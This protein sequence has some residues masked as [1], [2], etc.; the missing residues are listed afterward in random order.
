MWRQSTLNPESNVQFGEGGAGT[1]SDGKL[2][3]QIKDPHFL[4]RKVLSEFV[5][6][7][8]PPEI[9]YAS[10]PHIGT[11]KL[12]SMVEIMRATIESLGGEI[13]FEQRVIDI[14]IEEAAGERRVCGVML[15]GGESIATNHLVLA[16]GH[17][18]R[19]TFQCLHER[20]VFMDKTVRRAINAKK[21]ARPDNRTPSTFGLHQSVCRSRAPTR[22]CRCMGNPTRALRRRRSQKP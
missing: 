11:F 20:G 14:Q 5:A 1:F 4:G 21:N 18:A 8:A 2:W 3:S 13:R 10:K 17:S 19:D 22:A 12:V 16:I 6:A 7:G 15:A 9:M